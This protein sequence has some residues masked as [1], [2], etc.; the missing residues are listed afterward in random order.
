MR[1]SREVSKMQN[2]LQKYK[3]KTFAETLY[4]DS[5][6]D[7][8]KSAIANN[9][10]PTVITLISRFGM[11]K[12]VIDDLIGRAT[13]CENRQQGSFEPCGV[14]D[15]CT[16]VKWMHSLL[17]LDCTRMTIEQHRAAYDRLHVVPLN[18]RWVMS[19]DEFQRATPQ[20]SDLALLEVEKSREATFV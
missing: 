2:I 6:L 19:F 7:P 20:A 11:G 10:S 3:P 1:K 13:L 16:G 9:L 8:I 5:R 12:S 15:V 17:S 4:Q 14:C 18:R